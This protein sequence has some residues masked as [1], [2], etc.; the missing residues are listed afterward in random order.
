MQFHWY[1]FIVGLATLIAFLLA[2]KKALFVGISERI[3]SLVFFWTLFGGIIGA[4]A[5]HVWTDFYLYRESLL[6][7][8]YIWQGGLS[9]LGA[10]LGGFIGLYFFLFFSKKL[11]RVNLFLDS[12]IFGL[13]VA[14]AIGR[15]ANAINQELYGLPTELPWRIFIS[16]EKRIAGFEQFSYFHPLFLYEGLMVIIG[17]LILVFFEK[18]KRWQLGSGKFFLWYLIYYGIIRFFLDFLRIDRSSVYFGLGVNQWSILFIELFLIYIW[19]RKSNKIWGSYKRNF[20]KK[21]V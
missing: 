1:G 14:Q 8:F 10:I 9:I 11:K 15:V 12:F 17:W 2:E 19:F 18:T 7:I 3:F 5:W 6:D 4:R 20:E 16:P 21:N 13:P